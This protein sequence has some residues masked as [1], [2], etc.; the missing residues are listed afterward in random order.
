MIITIVVIRNKR[1][2]TTEENIYQDIKEELFNDYH[3]IPEENEF[4]D[5]IK[6]EDINPHYDDSA[7]VIVQERYTEILPPLKESC[8]GYIKPDFK[9]HK[10]IV[11]K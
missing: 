11:M 5:Q 6:Y 3:E 4:Y 8:D 9:P 10:Y 1:K 7:V 2:L